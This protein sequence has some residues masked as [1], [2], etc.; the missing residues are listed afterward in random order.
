[1]P[2]RRNRR[3]RRNCARCVPWTRT[4]GLKTMRR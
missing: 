4:D 1:V 2:R 3:R